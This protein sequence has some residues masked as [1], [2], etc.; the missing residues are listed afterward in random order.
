MLARTAAIALIMANCFQ[1][2]AA[3]LAKIERVIRKEPA[4]KTSPKYCLL[5]FGKE[6][7]THIWLVLDGTTLHV[8]RNGNGDL[9][10]PGEKQLNTN[11]T[12]FTID[13]LAERNGTVYPT[14]Q[15]SQRADGTFE[16]RLG[17][18][19]RRAQYVGIGRMEKPTWGDKPGTAPIIHFNGPLTFARYG[20]IYAVPRGAR[21]ND[22]SRR[23]KLR[24]LLGTPGLGKGT[25]ASY[26]EPLQ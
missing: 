20:A 8:D 23:F 21:E 4:Y 12:R 22:N 17:E 11:P 25:F 9:T 1:A 15:V 14:L 5:V 3:D 18:E 19:D 10:D 2:A 6:A 26:D 7:D 13:R 24:L 16:M